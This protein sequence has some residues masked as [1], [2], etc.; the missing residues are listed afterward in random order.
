MEKN[1]YHILVVDDDNKIKE[2]IKQ[3][4]IDKGLIVSTAS[5]AIEAKEKIEVF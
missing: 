1:K 4:L 3:F 2:L 5:N